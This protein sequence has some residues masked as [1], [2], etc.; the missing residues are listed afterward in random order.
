MRTSFLSPLKLG[1]TKSTSLRLIHGT[2]APLDF[3][4]SARETAK[5]FGGPFGR[6]RP[7]LLEHHLTWGVGDIQCIAM[8]GT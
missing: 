3:A 7:R 8:I 1:L 4:S 5:Y 6:Y 2:L